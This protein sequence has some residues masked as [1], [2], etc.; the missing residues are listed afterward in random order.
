MA[1]VDDKVSRQ[2]AIATALAGELQRQQI[3]AFGVDLDALANAV[4]LAI[5]PPPPVA[6]GKRPGDLNSANDD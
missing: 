1:M 4:E 5:D 2:R 3:D 6:E